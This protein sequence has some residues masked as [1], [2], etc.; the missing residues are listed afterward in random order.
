MHKLKLIRKWLLALVVLFGIVGLVYS[1]G[2]DEVQS[3]L[4]PSVLVEQPFS[5]KLV[6]LLYKSVDLHQKEV[7]ISLDKYVVKILE[8]NEY[9]YIYFV[10]SKRLAGEVGRRKV[11]SYQV[12]ASKKTFEILDHRG[13]M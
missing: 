1:M 12:T 4:S 6:A 3:E 13:I 2:E 10:D 7:G 5:G 9:Y 8:D 11:P